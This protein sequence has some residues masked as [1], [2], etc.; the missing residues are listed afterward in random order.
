[1]NKDQLD[2]FRHRELDE[3]AA[4]ENATCDAAK[5]VHHELAEEYAQRLRRPN[6]RS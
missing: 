3:R 2:Y 1:V 5:R 6:P 4:E